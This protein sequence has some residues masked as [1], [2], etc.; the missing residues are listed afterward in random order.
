MNMQNIQILFLLLDNVIRLASWRMV[1]E[2]MR[3][4]G[5][6]VGE[7]L[8]RGLA[9]TAV[10]GAVLL[11]LPP[12]SVLGAV[13]PSGYSGGAAVSQLR[14]GHPLLSHILHGF[15]LGLMVWGGLWL[16]NHALRAFM[17]QR[18]RFA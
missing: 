11:A 12:I 9:T 18:S 5:D 16:C 8:A 4:I 1:T 17:P 3:A 10:A 15:Y 6:G 2:I 14:I 13:L 7:N